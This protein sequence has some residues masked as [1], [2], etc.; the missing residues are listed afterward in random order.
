MLHHHLLSA[1]LLLMLA[2]LSSASPRARNKAALVHVR[3]EGSEKT[4]FEGI[5]LTRGHNLTATSGES[6]YCDGT[7]NKTYPHSVPTFTSA[8]DKAAKI[9]EFN[10]TAYVN[11]YPL[12]NII[13]FIEITNINTE[14]FFP[15]LTI[16]LSPLL[17]EKSGLKHS[18]GA[19]I[20]ISTRINLEVVKYKSSRAITSY[21]RSSMLP[22]LVPKHLF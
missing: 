11:L 7:N 13:F 6:H 8:L 17:R 10:Y 21:L 14:T 9:D 12:A 1:T 15:R 22:F 20:S 5:V 2:L 4:I 19:N 18:S 3:I 16:S